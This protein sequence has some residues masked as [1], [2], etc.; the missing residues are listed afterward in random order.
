[1]TASALLPEHRSWGPAGRMLA[2]I[3]FLVSAASL[4]TAA[5]ADSR[6]ETMKFAVTRNGM[7]IGT[8]TINVAHSG[9][10]TVVQI[11]THV[12]VGVAFVTL[13]KFDQTESEQWANGHLLAMNSVTDDNGAIHRTIASC[14]DGKLIV[15]GDGQVRKAAATLLPASL[16]NPALLTQ[17]VAL[18]PRDG[19]IVP[20]SVVDR[21]E[22]DLV[23]AGH[24]ERV[25]HYGLK[26]TFPEDV[27]YDESHRLVRVEMTGIDG[28]TIRYE[29]I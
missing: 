12:L 19:T 1:V 15:E 23:V 11:V 28:S 26:T 25:H 18:N 10:Q 16:W 17:N 29:L 9:S 21:G 13:Y 4:L 5:H 14:Q 7:E 27:W 24:S 22:D 2:A 20:V 6:S 3:A 8:N